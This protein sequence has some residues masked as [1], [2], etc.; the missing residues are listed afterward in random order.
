[1][2]T[3]QRF[4]FFLTFHLFFHLLS[5]WQTFSIFSN[6]SFQAIESKYTTKTFAS[7]NHCHCSL[8]RVKYVL[9]F[10]VCSKKSF[11]KYVT[12]FW[13]LKPLELH[14]LQDDNFLLVLTSP[15]CCPLLKHD[16]LLER[17]LKSSKKKK[18]VEEF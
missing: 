5:I 12:L 14:F 13:H 18:N 7:L 11:K 15:D 3:N 17:C 16:V 2:M 8:K 9:G 4:H 6:S 10:L 1:M